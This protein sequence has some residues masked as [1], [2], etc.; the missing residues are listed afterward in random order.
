MLL[1]AGP[2]SLLVAVEWGVA[3]GEEKKLVVDAR[4]NSEILVG[5]TME[6]LLFVCPRRL[7]IQR[8]GFLT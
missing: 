5:N 1:F 7:C 8:R 2:F 6:L 4:R 3:M